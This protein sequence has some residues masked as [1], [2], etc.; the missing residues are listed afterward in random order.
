MPSSQVEMRAL[1]LIQIMNRKLRIPV[2]IHFHNDIA[3]FSA[4]LPRE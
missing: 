2:L 1:S 4:F 3:S